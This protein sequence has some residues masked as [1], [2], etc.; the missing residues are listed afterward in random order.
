MRYSEE[1]KP[2]VRARIVAAASRVL[3]SEGIRG[4]SIPQLMK[5][6]GLTH[7]GFYAHFEDRDQL[8]AAAI[9]HAAEETAA[10]VLDQGSRKMLESYLSPEHVAHPEEGCVLAALGTDATKHGSVIRR[11]FARIAR[12]F[13]ER[14]HLSLHPS[15]R[16]KPTD[17]SLASAATMIG[18]V[19]L[20][21]AVDDET[22]GARILAAARQH[23][24]R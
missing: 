3:R 23:A 4:V 22:L 14:V 13:I 17:E 2:A 20:A 16:G 18:A 5:A 1:H 15:S 7:G 19:L 12:G 9:E 8:V 11:A 24:T 21:R 10:S 6:A